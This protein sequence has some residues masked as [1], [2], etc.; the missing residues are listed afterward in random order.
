M[1]GIV[2]LS[3]CDFHFVRVYKNL[4]LTPSN[5]IW[6]YESMNMLF[7]W[8]WHVY[9]L[10]HDGL[11]QVYRD[12]IMDRRFVPDPFLAG[13][14]ISNWFLMPVSG[15]LPDIRPDKRI[16]KKQT[17]FFVI[18]FFSKKHEHFL[19]KKNFFYFQK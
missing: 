13:Y 1:K 4:V 7:T 10:K 5:N 9:V 12:G 8:K 6:N 15:K 11:Y 3:S 17:I 2:I 19:A 16:L 14:R 18:K